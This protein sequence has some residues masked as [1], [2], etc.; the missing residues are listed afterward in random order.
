VDNESKYLPLHQR[1]Q[2]AVSPSCSFLRH[3]LIR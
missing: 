3:F 2:M 1:E